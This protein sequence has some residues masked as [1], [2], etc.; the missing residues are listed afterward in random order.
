MQRQEVTDIAPTLRGEI[1]VEESAR[2]ELGRDG[3]D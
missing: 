2:S 1:V 3:S